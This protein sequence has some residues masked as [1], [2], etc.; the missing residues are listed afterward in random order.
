MIRTAD[1]YPLW[2]TL[3]GLPRT[4]IQLCE[5]DILRDD[6]VCYAQGLREAGV[7]VRETLYKVGQ[8]L[9]FFYINGSTWYLGIPADHQQGLPHIFWVY[10]PELQVSKKAQDDAVSGLRWLMGVE[11]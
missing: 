2:G 8:R 4:Y 10:G 11:A 7:E 1:A 6:G 9:S 5:A 3:E